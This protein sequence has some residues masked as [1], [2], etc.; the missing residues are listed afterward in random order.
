MLVGY[1]RVSSVGQKLDVQLEKL[2]GCEK[3]FQE[4]KSGT[5]DQRP[6]L[7][8]CINFVREGDTLVVTKLDRLARSTLHLCK[9]S[10]M[11]NNKG[12]HLKVI[13]QCI[14][15]SMSTGRLLF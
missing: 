9:I 5:T 7:Q 8:E 11:L 4:K 14:D 2:N 15:T 10:D 6:A 1:A 13:D 12:V 3:I